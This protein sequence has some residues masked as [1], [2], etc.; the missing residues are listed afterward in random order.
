MEY[1]RE[2]DDVNYGIYNYNWAYYL[3]S[4]RKLCETGKGEPH[5]G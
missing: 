5:S 1:A 4:L 3:E 2:L